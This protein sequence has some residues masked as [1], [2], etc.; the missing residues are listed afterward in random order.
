MFSRLALV[1][2]CALLLAGAA[3]A[4]H[5]ELSAQSVLATDSTGFFD[6]MVASTPALA[7]SYR[8]LDALNQRCAN[9][10][11]GL[12]GNLQPADTTDAARSHCLQLARATIADMPTYAL[13]WYAASLFSFQLGNPAQGTEL[14]AKAQ[15]IGRHE[16]WIAEARV[17]LAEDHLA[18]LSDDAL[19]GHV[20]DLELLARSARGVR[21]IAYRYV[22]QPDFRERITLIVEQ[23]S[24]ED[25]IRFVANVR[26]AAQQF[27]IAAQ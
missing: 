16:Q 27:G 6:Q 4:A 5:R 20:Q 26:H 17:Q 25:Q 19:A 2:C 23:L 1:F 15:K 22:T 13:G 14:L 3:I 8:S 11:G 9:V 7:L 10:V 18:E 24:P 12:Y 21:S